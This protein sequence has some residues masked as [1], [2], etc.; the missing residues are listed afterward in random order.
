MKKLLIMIM[1]TASLMA[2]LNIYQEDKR[3]HIAV[4]G[5]ISAI[6]VGYFKNQGYSDKEAF[7]YGVAAGMLAGLAKE[8]YD[9][10]KYGGYNNAD[11]YADLVGSSVGGALSVQFS[12]KF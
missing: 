4:T 5:A 10:Y 7:F 12:W 9:E 3:K 2:D 11:M 6:T 1:F 8:A